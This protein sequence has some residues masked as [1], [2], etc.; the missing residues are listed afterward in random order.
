MDP[1]SAFIGAGG[2]VL[3]SM[4]TTGGNIASSLMNISN[5]QSMAS[6]AYLPQL[7][8]NAQKAGL[9]PLAVLGQHAPSAGNMIPGDV[10][11]GVSDAAR[12]LAQIKDPH[13]RKMENI[14]EQI[15]Q[16]TNLRIQSEA[17]NYQN[18]AAVKAIL[19]SRL[20]A[21]DSSDI[22]VTTGVPGNYAGIM[23]QIQN[24]DHSIHPGQMGRSVWDAVKGWF[25]GAPSLSSPLLGD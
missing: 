20:G 3:G 2:S 24:M 13:T 7:V 18:D 22:D 19:L 8:A 10:G 11:A 15:G 1:T 16:G 6:G 5:A 17:A 14:N 9:S 4:L 25:G 23:R 12:Q 21:P